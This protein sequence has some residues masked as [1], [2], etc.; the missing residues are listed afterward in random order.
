MVQ[1]WQTGLVRTGSEQLVR[2]LGPWRETSGPLNAAL[3][4]ALKGALIDGRV[5]PG[6]DLPGE[7]HLAIAL[8]VSRGTVTSALELLRADGWVQTRHGSASTAR[9]PPRAAERFAPVS[10]IGQGGSRID[11]RKAVPAA[12]RELYLD[13]TGRAAERAGRLLSEDGEPG[14]GLPELRAAIASAYSYEGMATRPEQILITGGA[15][16]A[17][18]LLASHFRPKMTVVENPTYFDALR[19]LR[20]SGSR[21]VSCGVT[22]DGWDLDQLREAFAAARG[23]VAYLVP[24]FQNPTGALMPAADRR[25]VSQL[26]VE[27]QVTVIVDETMRELDL[28]DHPTPLPRIRGAL[29]VGSTSKTIWGGLRIGWIRAPATLITDLQG[30]VL[31]GLLA[32]APMQQLVAVEMLDGIQP[33]LARRREELRRQRDYLAALIEDN[34]RWSFTV[35]SGGLA[36]WLRLKTVAADDVVKLAGHMGVALAAGPRFAADASLAHHLRVPFT[37]PVDVL[38]DVA[39]ALDEAAKAPDRGRR[40]R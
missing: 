3:A 20:A 23:G 4:S 27:H 22:T 17:L 21:L 38:D 18:M 2:A 25:L 16:A 28:R 39:A 29:L 1:S 14:P 31:A 35:P 19:L 24:D 10:A 34:D 7:R 5:R 30:H 37:P 36:L 9:L 26:A 8:G 6:S 13:A 15:R 40:T 11:L 33:V 32:A 12:P